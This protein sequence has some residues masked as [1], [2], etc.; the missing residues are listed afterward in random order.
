[1]S[2]YI[3][4]YMVVE[5]RILIFDK[6]ACATFHSTDGWRFTD[7]MKVLQDPRTLSVFKDFILP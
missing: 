6:D 5:T 4:V 2:S 1:M 7:T 3:N